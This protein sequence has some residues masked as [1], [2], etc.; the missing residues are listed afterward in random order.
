MVYP[1]SQ[2]SFISQNLSGTYYGVAYST[3]TDWLVLL[4]TNILN[5]GCTQVAYTAGTFFEWTGQSSDGHPWQGRIT[6]GASALTLRCSTTGYAFDQ[7]VA[8]APTFSTTGGSRV[9][10]GHC[11]LDHIAISTYWAGGGSVF[12]MGFPANKNAL[13]S[14]GWG[15]GTL[16]GASSGPAGSFNWIK[17]Y[18]SG[19]LATQ[20]STYYPYDYDGINGVNPNT[21]ECLTAE[22]VYPY[23]IVAGTSFVNHGPLQGVRSGVSTIVDKTWTQEGLIWYSGGSTYQGVAVGIA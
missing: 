17:S 22:I 11:A 20:L 16:R 8:A 9:V 6:V 23:L 19:T 12:Y 14:L 1:T 21:G 15:M 18:A 3:A 4:R 13:D 5:V 10:W 7:P 2:W